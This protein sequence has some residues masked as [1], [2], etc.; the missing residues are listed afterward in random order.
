MYNSSF[1]Q[2]IKFKDKIYY[3]NS[4]DGLKCVSNQTA[5]Q[6]SPTYS[7]NIVNEAPPTPIGFTINTK[8][9]FLYCLNCNKKGHS[10]KHCRFPVNSYGCVNFK[11]CSDNQ[12]RYLMIQKRHSHVYPELLRRKYNEFNFNYKYLTQ[13]IVNMPETDR[14]YILNY[15]FDYL[16]THYWQWKK[17]NESVKFVHDGYEDCKYKFNL[18][19]KGHNFPI[20][21]WLTFK[22]LFE[23]FPA[24]YLEPDW[25]FPKGRRE[26]GET[27][28]QCAIREC[29]EETRLLI[30]TDYKLF[31][32]V[33]PFQEKYIGINEINYC[34]S[35][36]LG[37][38]T[39]TNKFL[40]FDPNQSEQNNEI[41]KIGWFT[42]NEI[43]Q[44]D[45]F[46]S[47]HR[48]KMLSDI[49]RLVVNIKSIKST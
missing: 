37:E 18:L 6:I 12:I 26:E 29:E 1:Q 21:G 5:N 27:D 13:L 30:T 14:Y 41:R 22:S 45:N 34:N 31:L 32:H 17:K 48:S 28:Q 3:Y 7:E 11:M 43:T 16:W 4:K 36:Y 39:N 24:T 35:Y 23:Q 19:K 42:S 20:Y 10:Y 25:E 38:L 33:K 47:K 2:I 49:N 40:Y 44:L 9:N 15:D 46:S 8:K